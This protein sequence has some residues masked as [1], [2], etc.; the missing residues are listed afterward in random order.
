MWRNYF[1]KNNNPV[2]EFFL[3]ERRQSRIVEYPRLVS[4]MVTR[5]QSSH[6]LSLSVVSDPP[7]PLHPRVVPWKSLVTG[8]LSVL[9]QERKPT[10][11]AASVRTAIFRE[12]VKRTIINITVSSLLFEYFSLKKR[13]VSSRKLREKKRINDRGNYAISSKWIQPDERDFNSIWK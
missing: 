5:R 6:S 8:G 10:I 9:L 1:K 4:R 11:T 3:N 13:E 2:W 7:P 12:V